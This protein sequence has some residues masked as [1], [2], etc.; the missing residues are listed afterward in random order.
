MAQAKNGWRRLLLCRRA[1]SQSITSCRWQQ[2]PNGLR[3]H[4]T[5]SGRK[6]QVAR[7]CYTVIKTQTPGA[8]YYPLGAGKKKKG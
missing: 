3:K 7:G 6:M 4:A 8:A 1:W 2:C 5:I